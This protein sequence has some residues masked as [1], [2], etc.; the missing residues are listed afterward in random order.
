[1]V[2]AA[3]VRLPAEQ[4]RTIEMAFYGGLTQSEIAAELNEALGTVK[5]R[6]RRG[7][8]RLRDDLGT[9]LSS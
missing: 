9:R 1:M 6:I 5:A 4:R 7:M 2:R 8:L 3:L